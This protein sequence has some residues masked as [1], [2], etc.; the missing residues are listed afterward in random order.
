MRPADDGPTQRPLDR[1]FV[2]RAG[3][4]RAK[5][6]NVL[7]ICHWIN[8]QPA[9]IATLSLPRGVALTFGH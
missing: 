5:P 6:I 3:E 1:V 8:D 7:C 9:A 4:E 2:P